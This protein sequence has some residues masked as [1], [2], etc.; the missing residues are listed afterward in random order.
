M[1]EFESQAANLVSKRLNKPKLP[2]TQEELDQLL[3][4]VKK[5]LEKKIEETEAEQEEPVKPLPPMTKQEALDFLWRLIE[6]TGERTLT[7]R[8]R[9]IFSQL[10]AIFEQAILAERLGKKGRFYVVSEEHI[11][12]LMNEAKEAQKHG[13]KQ[14]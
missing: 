9:F 5:D 8:E 13:R 1:N 14:E 6:T 12:N 2:W 11:M 4:K 3:P 10:L 7:S